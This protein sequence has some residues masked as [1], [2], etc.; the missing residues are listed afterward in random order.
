MMRFTWD[1]TAE[2]GSSP[3]DSGGP[4]SLARRGKTG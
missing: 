1:L 2:G 4:G 3:S